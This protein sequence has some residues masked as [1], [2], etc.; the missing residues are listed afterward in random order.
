M[1]VVVV[2]QL[3]SRRDRSQD[4]SIHS[5][6]NETLLINIGVAIL[7]FRV[8]IENQWYENMSQ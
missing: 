1:S 3:A 7:Y 2:K 6:E 4:P 8:Y 5:L